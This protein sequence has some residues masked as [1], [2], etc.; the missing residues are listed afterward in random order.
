MKRVT[1]HKIYFLCFQTTHGL[2]KEQFSLETCIN[3]VAPPASKHGGTRENFRG[4]SEKIHVKRA[5][6]CYFYHFY[7]VIVKFGLS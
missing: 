3:A 5:K 4:E 7:T 2:F 1:C 6:I